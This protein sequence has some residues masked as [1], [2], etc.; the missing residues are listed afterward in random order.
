MDDGG[1]GLPALAAPHEDG[2]AIAGPTSVGGMNHEFDL[3]QVCAGALEVAA[4]AL[5]LSRVPHKDAHNL[6]GADL[7]GARLVGADL[8]SAKLTGA[9]LAGT[10]LRG[11]DLAG[12]SLIRANLTGANLAGVVLTGFFSI[13]NIMS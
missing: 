6:T 2:A 5:P 1:F 9:N 8:R 7:S 13:F 11:Q 10:D 3:L 4:R 12:A